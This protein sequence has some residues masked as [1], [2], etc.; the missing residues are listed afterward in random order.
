MATQTFSPTVV[1]NLPNGV[2]GARDWQNES[3]AVSDNS[4]YAFST[5]DSTSAITK[6]LYSSGY[7]FSIP[8][9]AT[10]SGFAVTIQKRAS[11]TVQ[12]HFVGLTYPDGTNVSITFPGKEDGTN[13]TSGEGTSTY[14]NSNDPWNKSWTYSEVNDVNFGVVISAQGNVG[15]SPLIDTFKVTV[16][17]SRVYAEV[18]S[19][20]LAGG[21]DSTNM[22]TYNV[23]GS[24]GAVVSRQDR[25]DI[26]GSGGAGLA[27]AADVFTVFGA[28]RTSDQYTFVCKGS[29][30]VP[31]N[32]ATEVVH[33]SLTFNATNNV[34]KWYINNTIT[35]ID[36]VRFRGPAAEGATAGTIIDALQDV[37][38]NPIIGQAT[39]TTQQMTDLQNGLWYL[40]MREDTSGKI[41]RGQ[42]VNRASLGASGTTTFTNDIDATGGVVAAG[43]GFFIWSDDATGGILCGGDNTSTKGV[44][45]SASGGIVAGGLVNDVTKSYVINTLGG[46]VIAGDKT[47]QVTYETTGGNEGVAIGGDR[48]VGI[49]PYIIPA[50][51]RGGGIGTAINNMNLIGSGG[52]ETSPDSN[53]NLFWL[54][55]PVGDGGVVVDGQARKERIHQLQ[56][57]IISGIGNSLYSENIL[58]EVPEVTKLLTPH[59]VEDQPDLDD[60]GFRFEVQPNW[61]FIDENVAVDCC[62]VV[63]EDNELATCDGAIPRILGGRQKHY[64][65]LKN[66][67][68]AAR[69]RRIAVIS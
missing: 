50:G 45:I 43:R 16:T 57:A 24:G 32:S 39:V 14:G 47:I 66:R 46:A 56:K 12:D 60:P 19:G 11:G 26:N 54:H 25:H 28:T 9:D 4:L 69:D 10:I 63:N 20:G 35:G 40:Y 53:L 34:V 38:V 31:P 23:D 8:S 6:Y 59:T 48:I 2:T 13:W 21:G 3:D 65:P 62:Q 52:V 68:K 37:G 67:E 42:V 29:Q 55:N 33:A 44:S 30:V 18:G 5:F 22:L 7:N 41:I 36:A 27:G 15:S 58:Q 17:Y 51:V 61:C 64:L 49:T 1:V